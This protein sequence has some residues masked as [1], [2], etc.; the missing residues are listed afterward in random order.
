MVDHL[1]R[2]AAELCDRAGEME[3]H[4][5]AL[6]SVSQN[7]VARLA[8]DA[9]KSRKTGDDGSPCARGCCAH[10]LANRYGLMLV[11][12]V[13]L[14]DSQAIAKRMQRHHRE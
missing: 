7:P 2:V 11:I 6:D 9:A 4:V 10:V 3:E 1:R 5:H 12:R 13:P 8:R 14:S